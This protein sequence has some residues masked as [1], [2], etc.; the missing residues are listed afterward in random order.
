MKKKS[1]GEKVLPIKIEKIGK[2]R[3]PS[4][5]YDSEIPVTDYR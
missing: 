2:Y 3:F 5:D 4:L 1:G